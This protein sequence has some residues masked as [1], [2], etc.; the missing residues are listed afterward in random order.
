MDSNL[1]FLF[2]RIQGSTKYFKSWLGFLGMLDRTSVAGV[3]Q[4][5]ELF[6]ESS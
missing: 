5:L 6:K 3:S 2:I 1:N 4:S